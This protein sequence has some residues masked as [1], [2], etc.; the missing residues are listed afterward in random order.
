MTMDDNEKSIY[1]CHR[2]PCDIPL[3]PG[4][5]IGILTTAYEIIPIYLGSIPSLELTWHLKMGRNPKGKD[6]I[7]TIHFQ[8]RQC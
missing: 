2:Y 6:R 4:W 5:S 8:V 1:V 3:N 7:P